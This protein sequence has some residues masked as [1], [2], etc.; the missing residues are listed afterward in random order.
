MTSTET[1]TTIATILGAVRAWRKARDNQL[2]VQ[3]TIHQ[4]FTDPRCGVLAPVF[5][6]L[7]SLYETC[8]GRRFQI[9]SDSFVAISGDEHRLLNLLKGSS[10]CEAPV[11]DASA[12]PSLVPTLRIALRS[13]RIMLRLALDSSDALTSPDFRRCPLTPDIANDTQE[14]PRRAC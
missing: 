9:G 11:L 3:R 12:R 8:S 6:S 14:H 5:D 1:S 2:P 7:L 4:S 10:G 13:A